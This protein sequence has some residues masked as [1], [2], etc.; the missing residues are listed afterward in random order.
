MFL[1]WATLKGVCRQQEPL[2]WLIQLPLYPHNMR[3][4]MLF[5]RSVETIADRDERVLPVLRQLLLGLA[6]MHKVLCWLLFVHKVVFTCAHAQMGVIH[7]DLKPE[8]VLMSEDGDPVIAD[9]ETSKQEVD[10]PGTLT[11][12]RAVVGT[13]GYIAPEVMHLYTMLLAGM[14]FC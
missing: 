11:V 3:Q 5:P 4:W 14:P 13:G 8:N 10:L 9:M 6:Y 7:R 2:S 1:G 12:T